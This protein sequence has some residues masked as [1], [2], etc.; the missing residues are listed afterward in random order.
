M[1]VLKINMVICMMFVSVASLNAGS[2]LALTVSPGAFTA[3]NVEPGEDKDTGIDLT[4]T[5]DTDKEREFSIKV[6]AP[7]EAQNKSLK[8]YRTL[9]ELGWFRLE[10]KDLIVPPGGQGKS[11]IFI[12]IPK[13]EKYYNQHWEVSCLLE[14]VGQKG[15][16]QEAVMTRYMI[17]TRTKADVSESPHGELGIAPAA[18]KITKQDRKEGKEFGFKIY[19]NTTEVRLYTIKSFVPKQKSGKLEINVTPGLAWAKKSSWV[20]PLPAKIKV[21]PGA[22]GEVKLKV[23]VPEKTITPETGVEALIFIDSEQGERRFVRVQIE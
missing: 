4:V 23:S 3:Q 13:N 17:E 22:V 6:V 1:K 11:R 9:P 18:V 20:R 12:N 2:A 16:F 8:G 19:N 7:K 21:E 15:L 14:Y 5:N 10:K